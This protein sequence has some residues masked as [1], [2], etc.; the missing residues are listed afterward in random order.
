MRKKKYY[1]IRSCLPFELKS[2]H[3]IIKGLSCK[4]D[5]KLDDVRFIKK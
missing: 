3:S 1:P 4:S 5:Y 2:K